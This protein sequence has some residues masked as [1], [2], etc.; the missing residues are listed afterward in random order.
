MIDLLKSIFGWMFSLLCPKEGQTI[1]QEEIMCEISHFNMPTW[2]KKIFV[3]GKFTEVSCKYYDKKKKRCVQE[4]I[5]CI[6]ITPIAKEEADKFAE[7][8]RLKYD[9][10]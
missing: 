1:T 6:L 9:D 8:Y 3:D 2:P 7:K 4:N 10:N 5:P